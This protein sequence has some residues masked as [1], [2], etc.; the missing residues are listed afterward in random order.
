MTPNIN[1]LSR[2]PLGYMLGGCFFFWGLNFPSV[3]GCILRKHPQRGL[4]Q[5]TESERMRIEEL[6]AEGLG[7]RRISAITGLSPNTVK[8]YIRRRGD[9]HSFQVGQTGYECKQCHKPIQQTPHKRQKVFCSDACRM[10]WWNA[11]PEKVQR[12][13]NH[14]LVCKQCGRPFISYSN[15][16]RCFCSRACYAEYRKKGDTSNELA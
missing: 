16:H 6:N 12:K 8:S 14:S 15:A 3:C 9:A 4:P 10:A 13:A 5:M 2:H 11:H 7:Y 1:P